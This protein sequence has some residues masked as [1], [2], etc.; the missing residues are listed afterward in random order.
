[1]ASIPFSLG[2]SHKGDDIVGDNAAICS[3][4]HYRM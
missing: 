1:M 4:V 2:S 3:H